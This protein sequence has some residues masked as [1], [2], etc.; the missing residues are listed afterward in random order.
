MAS[1]GGCKTRRAT[2]ERPCATNVQT[3][4]NERLVDELAA[5]TLGKESEAR[6]PNIDFQLPAQDEVRWNAAIAAFIGKQIEAARP[7]TPYI[8]TSDIQ[9]A[10]G[11]ARTLDAELRNQADVGRGVDNG[12]TY[13]H[14]GTGAS[15]NPRLGVQV[16][17]GT[18]QAHDYNDF[19]KQA[20][21]R[22]QMAGLGGRPY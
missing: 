13:Q 4:E 22:A 1:T 21:R 6:D 5:I 20:E 19:M 9:R 7:F 18:V 12:V 8:N 3:T 16:N 10:I 14:G 2:S 11:M 15:T 17:I